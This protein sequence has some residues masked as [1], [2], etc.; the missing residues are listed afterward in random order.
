LA[1]FT[2]AE[3][4]G[5]IRALSRQLVAVWATYFTVDA[6][7]AVVRARAQAFISEQLGTTESDFVQLFSG[8]SSATSE[9]LLRM[10]T[11][12]RAVLANPA[13]FD[14]TLAGPAAAGAL[15]VYLEGFGHRATEWED[16]GATLAER[17]ERAV[18]LLGETLARVSA[19]QPSSAAESRQ[20]RDTVV[21]EL[22]RKL[23]S[24]SLRLAFDRRLRD[25]Q[26]TFAIHE[27]NVNFYM[28]GSGYMRYALLEA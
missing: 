27:E 6:A 16:A 5:H 21:A 19:G 24:A 2:D 17:P 23:S 25:A 9:P 8:S 12:A 4:T 7:A 10:E 13:L 28:L 15:A 26:E 1:Q 20:R 14:E 3:F 22:R 11:L 18:E